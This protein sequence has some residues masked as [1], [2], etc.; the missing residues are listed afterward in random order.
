[1]GDSYASGVGAGIQPPDQMNRCFRMTHA[2]PVIMQDG[3]NGLDPAP[4]KFNHVACSGNTFDKIK[5]KELLDQP[6]EDGKYG[7]RPAWGEAPEFVTITMGGNDIG[8]LNLVATCILSIK[9]IGMDCDKVIQSAFDEI[10]KPEF[11]AGLDDLMNAIVKKGRGTRVGDRF[12]VF[13]VGYAQFF[14]QETTQCDNVDFRPR[15][16]LIKAEKLTTGRRKAMNEL[17]L[18]LNE[19][20]EDLVNRFRDQ[21]VFWIDYDKEFEGHRFCDREE[22]SPNDPDTW[23]FN[24][25]TQ[26]D[27]MMLK[28]QKIIEKTSFYQAATA[29]SQDENVKTDQDYIDALAD[30]VKD[31]PDAQ[32]RLSDT[33][34]VM[35]PTSRGHE[36]IRDVIIRNLADH[37]I[38]VGAAN[39]TASQ[40]LAAP[41][42]HGVG[43]DTWML[44]RDQAI[45]AIQQ[46]CKQTTR[47][48]EYVK[49]RTTMGTRANLAQIF[50][51]QRRLCHDICNER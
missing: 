3:P 49:S 12:K 9:P 7:T 17:A 32:S 34:R 36:M 51:R 37:G 10:K 25:Y 23:F 43:G 33:V 22:P 24:Y 27:P 13:V 44:S 40:N 15:W 6:Q 39:S 42:C 11:N 14:N 5:D 8:I 18:A 2:H 21:G 31:D 1:M 46:F 20:L 4:S 41:T 45:S 16:S 28:A 26:D 19:A 50:S 30:A 35:H 29:G 38:I 47:E 48:K